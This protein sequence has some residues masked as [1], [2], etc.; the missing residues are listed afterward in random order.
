MNE[1]YFKIA[2]AG[3]GGVGKSCL[4]M[5][6]LRD[7][8]LENYDP[9]FQ[10]F[11][12]NDVMVDDQVA[13]LEIMD[14]AYQE[15]YTPNRDRHLRSQDGFVCVFSLTSK[16]TVGAVKR[17]LLRIRRVKEKDKFVGVLIANKCDLSEE[18]RA[19]SSDV[20]KDL[21][22]EFNVPYFECSAKTGENVE[23][24]FHAIVREIRNTRKNNRR[25]G[26]KNN[27]R[28][29]RRRKKKKSI[30]VVF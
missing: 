29:R 18:E 24:S 23:N 5:R 22:R 25:R 19:F 3:G 11:Y 10:D 2:I 6:F 28:R 8:F 14:I 21:A 9:N 17:A 20:G 27:R 13:T 12:R 15:E 26:R 4:A 1:N 16:A 30:C 7:I